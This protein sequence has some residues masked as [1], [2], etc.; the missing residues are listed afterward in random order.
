VLPLLVIVGA[1]AALLYGL[2]RIALTIS[3][4]SGSARERADR[5]E[6]DLDVAK[7]QGEIIAENRG[8]EDAASTLDRGEF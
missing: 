4:E 6:R 3:A 7:R 5:A 1:I 2:G 8:T